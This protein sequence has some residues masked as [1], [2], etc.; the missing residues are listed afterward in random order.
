MTEL[1]NLLTITDV[2]KKLK[3]TPQYARKLIKEEKLIATRIGSQ[4]VIKP[5]DLE[6]YKKQY[7]ILVEPDDHERLNDDL[8]EIVALSFFLVQWD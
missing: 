7:D 1:Q 5:E 3:V 6:R 2:A 4:W 8:P